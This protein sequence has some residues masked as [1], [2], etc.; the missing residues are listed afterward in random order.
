MKTKR[1]M[2]AVMVALVAVFANVIPAF[3]YPAEMPEVT[4]QKEQ[5]NACQLSSV[6]F[7]QIDIPSRR[8]DYILLDRAMQCAAGGKKGDLLIVPVTGVQK[9]RYA[10]FKELQAD[11]MSGGEIKSSSANRTR[12]YE[13]KAQQAEERSYGN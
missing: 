12:F 1:S 2:F 9:S 8:I 3:A 5:S 10:I 4:P 6:A 13:F 11:L 7:T